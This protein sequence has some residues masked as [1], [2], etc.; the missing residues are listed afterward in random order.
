MGQVEEIRQIYL[1]EWLGFDRSKI[2]FREL[3]EGGGGG[4]EDVSSWNR[5]RQNVIS[6]VI[7]LKGSVSQLQQHISNHRG[8][9]YEGHS[10]VATRMDVVSRPKPGGGFEFLKKTKQIAKWSY[11]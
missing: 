9:S 4:G 11:F 10:R 6:I 2:F 3:H 8:I 5:L 1:P 7:D